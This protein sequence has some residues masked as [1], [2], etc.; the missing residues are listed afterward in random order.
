MQPVIGSF[1]DNGL[2][3]HG[4]DLNSFPTYDEKVLTATIPGLGGN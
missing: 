3:A 1:T 2:S 4:D